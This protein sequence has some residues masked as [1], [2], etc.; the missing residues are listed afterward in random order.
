MGKSERGANCKSLESGTANDLDSGLISAGSIPKYMGI[1]I[2]QESILYT[3]DIGYHD[4]LGTIH[5]TQGV[6]SHK[7]IRAFLGKLAML[8]M[9]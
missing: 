1:E 7:A 2:D 5:N 3:E 4:Y 8:R 6:S 9:I